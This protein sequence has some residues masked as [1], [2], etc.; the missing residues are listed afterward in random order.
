MRYISSRNVPL[1]IYHGVPAGWSSSE[2]IALHQSLG[3]KFPISGADAT[4]PGAP[5]WLPDRYNWLQYRETLRRI[6]DGVKAGD[7]ACVELAIRYIELDYFGSY[8]GFMKSRF[9]RLLKSR[10][11][12]SSQVDR[13]N[14]CFATL[15]KS[16]RCFE[17]FKEYN[18]L[19][20]RLIKK[21]GQTTI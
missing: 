2:V 15:I 13:L 8:S 21:P 19:R 11:L 5:Q 7:P 17:E 16:D 1:E 10:D 3:G 20:K 14:E 9:A 4:E 6:G 12:S 18:K